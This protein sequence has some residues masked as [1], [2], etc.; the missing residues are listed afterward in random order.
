MGDRDDS[1]TSET[2]GLSPEA[3]KGGLGE[4]G[5]RL[6]LQAWK[7]GGRSTGDGC[8]PKRGTAGRPLTC[9]GEG[10]RALAGRPD[11]LAF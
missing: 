8:A 4:A 7:E 3:E 11:P 5:E 6:G 2:S 1:T 9:T 10:E